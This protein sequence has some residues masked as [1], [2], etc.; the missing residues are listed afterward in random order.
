MPNAWGLTTHAFIFILL[1]FLGTL[2]FGP[3]RW[4]CFD[5]ILF[6]GKY[7]WVFTC[8]KRISLFKSAFNLKAFCFCRG[9]RIIWVF[10]L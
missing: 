6:R 9:S 7:F 10:Y 2:Y 8:S 3:C 1:H 5:V 4:H